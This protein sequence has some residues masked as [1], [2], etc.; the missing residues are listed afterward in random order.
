[1]LYP[2]DICSIRR[3]YAPSGG[4]MLYSILRMLH[5]T[6]RC[7]ILRSDMA[8]DVSYAPFEAAKVRFGLKKR[9]LADC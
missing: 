3:T 1:M 6:H 7:R 2:M 4:H 9:Y 8:F 5:P